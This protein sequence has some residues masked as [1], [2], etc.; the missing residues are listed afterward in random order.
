MNRLWTRNYLGFPSLKKFRKHYSPVCENVT[1]TRNSAYYKNPHKIFDV[2]FRENILFT[3][4]R[5]KNYK[6]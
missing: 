5:M 4:L 6:L 3:T 1:P 2:D